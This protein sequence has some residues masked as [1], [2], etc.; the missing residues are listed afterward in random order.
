ML[1]F[2]VEGWRWRLKGHTKEARI[3]GVTNFLLSIVPLL[4]INGACT[5]AY[6]MVARWDASILQERKKDRYC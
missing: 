1:G 2:G 5:Y 3:L 4:G 6:G